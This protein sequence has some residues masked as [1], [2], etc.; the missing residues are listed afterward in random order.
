MKTDKILHLLAGYCIAI[1]IGMW[2]PFVGFATGVVI[3]AAK[4]LIYDH[5]LKRGVSDVRDFL[6]TALGA[7]VGSVVALIH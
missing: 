4:E 1:T 3:G 6:V 7:A 2:S 5:L